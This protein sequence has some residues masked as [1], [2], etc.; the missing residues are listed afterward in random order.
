MEPADVVHGPDPAVSM[1]PVGTTT[2]YECTACG[3]QC[4]KL[5]D[6]MLPDRHLLFGHPAGRNPGITCMESPMWSDRIC[7]RPKGHQGR[8]WSPPHYEW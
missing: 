3:W 6:A 4:T 7:C 5:E 8:H 2:V 1:Q